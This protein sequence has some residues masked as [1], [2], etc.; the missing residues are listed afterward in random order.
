MGQI[1][2]LLTGAGVTTVIPGQ[3]QCEAMI[4]LGDVD[5]AFPLQGVTIEVDGS[6]FFNVQSA[7]LLTAYAKWMMQV[8]ATVIG[9]V[10]KVATGMMPRNTTYRLTN[11]GATTPGIFAYSD[12]DNGVPFLCA[13]KQI[14]ALSYED[15]DNFSA[16]FIST[17]ANV[18]NYEIVFSNGA[19]KTY[20]PVEMDAY[21]ALQFS[22]EVDGRLAG[23]TVLDNRDKKFSKVRVNCTAVNTVMVAKLPDAA[24]KAMNR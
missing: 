12:N 23:V 1:G 20:A 18:L 15:F 17:P 4:L 11:A 7:A 10:L 21:F 24:F 9:I 2:T 13:T 5:T 14:N 16:L 3:A 6:P 19:K 8:T 22:T